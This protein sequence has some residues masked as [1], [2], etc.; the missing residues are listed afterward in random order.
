MILSPIDEE[1]LGCVVRTLP[2]SPRLL[3]Q[4]APRLQNLET[5]VVDVTAVLRRDPALTA[6]L[7]SI[8]NSAV[9]GRNGPAISLED[10]VACIGFREVYRIVGALASIQLSEEP[11]WFHDITSPQ[12]RQNALFVAL[13]TEELATLGACEPR[14]AYTVGLLRS[15]GKLAMDRSAHD[16]A[17]TVP[18]RP[19]DEPLLDWELAHWGTSNAEVG[20]R[21]LSHW[22]FP[23]EIVEAIRDHYAPAETAAPLAHLLH[24][25][26]GAADLRGYGFLG[27]ES[28]WQFAPTSFARTHV[29]EGKLVWAAERAFQS[30]AR[31]RETLS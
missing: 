16:H 11:L 7:I 1:E 28:Y 29:D 3:A 30:L 9:Y 12:F 20:A 5:P 8:A 21:I 4:L 22:G 26:A 6:R 17:S 15:I 31:L 27:E 19:E 23:T 13:V 2:A 10:A 24:L 14:V 18:R 25:A